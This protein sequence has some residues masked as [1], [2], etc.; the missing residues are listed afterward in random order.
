MIS[1]W[2]RFCRSRALE[3]LCIQ[4]SGACSALQVVLQRISPSKNQELSPNPKS[5]QLHILTLRYPCVLL[6]SPLLSQSADSPLPTGSTPHWEYCF[7]VCLQQHPSCSFP[8][9]PVS[10]DR[11][12]GGVSEESSLEQGMRRGECTDECCGEGGSQQ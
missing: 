7:S 6:C 9:T 8:C 12:V 5:S 11:P 4:P 2:F 3:Q 10:T 1:V